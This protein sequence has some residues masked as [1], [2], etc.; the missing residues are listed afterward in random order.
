L[1]YLYNSW[2][3]DHILPV[4]SLKTFTKLKRL[5]FPQKLLLGADE[6][7][8]V[9]NTRLLF[10]FLPSCL[11]TLEI[12]FPSEVVFAFFDRLL[13]Q[14]SIFTSLK[15]VILHCATNERGL[16]FADA[17]G[18]GG[19]R[20]LW[21]KKPAAVKQ[22]CTAGLRPLLTLCDHDPPSTWEDVYEHAALELEC[23]IKSL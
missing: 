15:D 17:D 18:S 10:H 9:G 8:V 5:R 22:L 19:M 6:P 1:E 23:F 21:N 11:E 20:K 12:E 13:Q 7:T 2:L 3:L 14:R 16:P 4:G